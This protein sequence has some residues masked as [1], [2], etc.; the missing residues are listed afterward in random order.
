MT[1]SRK[2]WRAIYKGPI[3]DTDNSDHS[4]WKDKS[5]T[6]KFRE[7]TSLIEQAIKLKGKNY[8]DLSKLLR[9]TAVLKRQ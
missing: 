4:Y 7:V 9:S 3:E 2:D 8:A 5:A 6:E 1:T